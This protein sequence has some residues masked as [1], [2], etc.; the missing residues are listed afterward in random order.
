MK[1][2]KYILA[3]FFFIS[4]AVV[5][6]NLLRHE[7]F[8]VQYQMYMDGLTQRDL[9]ERDMTF[10]NSIKTDYPTVGLF[11][12]PLAAQKG[13]YLIANDSIYSGIK[14][15]EKG[16][17]T[18]P[19]IMYSEGQLADIYLKLGSNDKFE[20][21]TRK[22]FSNLPNN[23][24]HFVHLVK[25][26]KSQNKNDSIVYY[27][28]QIKDVLGPKDPQVYNIVLSS[29][30]LDKDTLTKYNA[31]EIAK[32]GLS[33]H[34]ESLKLVHDFVLYG[35]ENT[36]KAKEKYSEGMKEIQEGTYDKGIDLLKEAIDLHPNFQLYYDN[37]I[38]ANF[39]KN[40]F[41][42]IADIRPDYKKY[43]IN[44]EPDIIFYIASSLYFTKNYE[45]SCILLNEISNK[46]IFEFDKSYFPFCF[47]I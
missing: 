24:L 1:S 43:F 5:Y 10:I 44:V 7:S 42:N 14:Y 6:L 22:A 17:T 46:N 18:N 25:L 39:N 28:N 20:F 8:I 30:I 35:R 29:L 34:P 41:K 19:Y 38:V 33:F 3:F 31:V 36:E 15:L 12:M 2:K 23:P 13:A 27:Y 11:G 21:Y 37:Y 9:S 40:Y 32:E 4:L 47:N 16:Q 26:L 45:D